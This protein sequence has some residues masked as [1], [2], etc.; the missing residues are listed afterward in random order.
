M[1]DLEFVGDYRQPQLSARQRAH[2][3]DG[4]SAGDLSFGDFLDIIN[5]L[6][7]IPLVSTLYREITGDEISP[8]AR[9]LGD[10]LF[11]GPTGFL[12]S[13]ANVLY[14]EITGEDVGE[15][16]V[17]FF[18][19]DEGDAGEPQ[20]AGDD[21]TVSPAGTL[22][23]GQPAPLETAAG[24]AGP[25]TAAPAAAAPPTDGSGTEVSG[26]GETA[27]MLP[28]A[29]PGM[30]TG[31]D[32]LDALFMDLRGSRQDA[33]ALPR[34]GTPGQSLPLPGRTAD[35]AAAKSYP[36]PPR[37]I[38]VAAPTEPD[39]AAPA[40]GAPD[41]AAAEA[42]DAAHPLLFAQEAADGALADRMMQALDKYQ[43]MARQGAAGRRE[44]DERQQDDR[45]LWQADPA[46]TAPAGS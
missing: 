7:H 11:G 43:A 15:T 8:H 24:A 44:D 18:S 29:A 42:E 38:R 3:H 41:A 17:A 13:V 12:S 37:H 34:A 27:A 20:F 31:Q 26:T 46:A 45:V 4:S 1:N 40:T 16:V 19:G 2:G 10:T 39:A 32:A 9:I 6:Q 23:G 30:L 28:E 22:P 5:P 25:D 14:Q 21:G 35:G 36:L 33:A